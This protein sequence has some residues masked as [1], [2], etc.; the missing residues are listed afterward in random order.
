MAAFPMQDGRLS[1]RGLV[2]AYS[3]ETARKDPALGKV[4]CLHIVAEVHQ[5]RLQ[6][7]TIM[8]CVRWFKLSRW[9]AGI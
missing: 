1:H 2:L 5:S 8:Y 7:T 9:A 3:P 4:G 6:I